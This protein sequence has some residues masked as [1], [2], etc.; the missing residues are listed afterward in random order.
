MTKEEKAILKSLDTIL[1]VNLPDVSFQEFL[2]MLKDKTGLDV[3][4]S[5]QAMEEA[6]VQYD[7]KLKIRGKAA[8]R[9]LLRKVLADLGLT[10]VV[11]DATV[12]V[13]TV[14]RAKE[15]MT[16]RSYYLGDLAP[17]VDIRWG[18]VISQALMA[19]NMV[20]LVNMITQSIEPGSWQVN[21]GAGTIA[22]QPATMTIIVRQSAEV[23]YLLGNGIR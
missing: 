10:Y 21:G 22:F 5:K 19:Q 4:V 13:T 16:T 17:V 11:K 15:M 20:N 3:L 9:T 12:Q 6:S 18:P 14:A 1:D 2:D 8:T 23:H 7:T